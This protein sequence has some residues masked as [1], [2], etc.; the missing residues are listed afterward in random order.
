MNCLNNRTQNEVYTGPLVLAGIGPAQTQVPNNGDVS[1]SNITSSDFKL[2]SFLKNS[3][4][5]LKQLACLDGTCK[6]HSKCADFRENSFTCTKSIDKTFCG[7]YNQF[8]RGVEVQ[9]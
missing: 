3:V 6:Y 9:A 1:M 2:S 8:S 5:S 4:Q 7:I